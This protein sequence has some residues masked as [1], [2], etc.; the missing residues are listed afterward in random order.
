MFGMMSTEGW[1]NVMWNAV[2]ATE[3][4]QVPQRNFSPGYIFFFLLF[5]IIGSLFIL[6]LFV[7][8]VINTFNQEK[9]KLSNN[10]K[11]TDLQKEYVEVM[12]KCY[13][14]NPYKT[15]K[16]HHNKIRQAFMKL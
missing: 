16:K 13:S 8:V 2:D 15:V 5:M 3:I 4:Y 10:N 14:T 9:E 11:M 6:N 12:I 1:L 7:G